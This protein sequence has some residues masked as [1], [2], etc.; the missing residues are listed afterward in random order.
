MTGGGTWQTRNSANVVT[1]SGTY[2]VEELVRW[3]FDNFQTN[4]GFVDNIDQGRGANGNAVLRISFSDG[5]QGVL[6]IG[7]HGPGADPGIFE[8]VA[9]T[10]AY[11]T[12]YDVQPPTPGVDGNRTTFHV[13]H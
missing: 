12:Y 6:T 3:E 8:G 4:V 13:R 5:S 10:K 2:T 11:K 7:C 1:G 9:T